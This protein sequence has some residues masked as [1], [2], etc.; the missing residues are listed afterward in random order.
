MQQKGEYRIRGQKRTEEDFEEEIEEQLKLSTHAK[1]QRRE[2]SAALSRKPHE[3]SQNS[4][5]ADSRANSR[6]GSSVVGSRV[7]RVLRNS[8]TDKNGVVDIEFNNVRWISIVSAYDAKRLKNVTVS[9][10]SCESFLKRY[11]QGLKNDAAAM[12][13]LKDIKR[14]FHSWLGRINEAFS[15]VIDG[16]MR[17]SDRAPL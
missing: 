3:S 13:L 16:F 8:R 12:A 15:E 10:Q 2:N 17:V 9:K 4:R 7:G 6:I 1:G 14:H 11:G 5:I